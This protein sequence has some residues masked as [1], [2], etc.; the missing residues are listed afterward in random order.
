MKNFLKLWPNAGSVLLRWR[1]RRLGS[2]EMKMI[3]LAALLLGLLSGFSNTWARWQR[4][5]EAEYAVDFENVKV[6][7]HKDATFNLETEVSLEIL[8]D[9]A[10]AKFGLTRLSYNSRSSSFKVL[11]A[12][13]INGDRVL[14]VRSEH[15]ENK[16]LASSG[17]G[18]DEI[19]QVTIAFPEVNVGSKLYMRFTREVTKT[20]IP[21][22]FSWS[23]SFGLN[24]YVK[25][26]T[27]QVDSDMPLNWEVFDPEKY[28]QVEAQGKGVKARLL[29]PIYRQVTEEEN[30]KT[31]T[32][33]MPWLGITSLAKWSEFPKQTLDVYE[34]RLSSPLP[35]KYQ[36]IVQQ[37]KSKNR[38][39]DVI[40]EVIS[41][42][43][44][45]IRY[46][47]DWVP[48]E[49]AIHPRPLATVAETGFGDCKDFATGAAAMLRKLGFDA[50]A[51][52]V[53]RDR[54][55]TT[56]PLRV[57]FFN[58]N[59]T[60]V[61]AEKGGKT[62]WLDPTNTT[63]FAQGLY[64]DI[65]NREALVL[66]DSPVLKMIPPITDAMGSVK[67]NAQVDIHSPRSVE[68][69]GSISLLGHAMVPFTGLALSYS[70]ASIDYDLLYFVSVPGRVD[71]FHFDDFDLSSRIVRDLTT[72]F[73]V[74]EKWLPVPTSAGTGYLVSPPRPIETFVFRRED[75]Q[76]SLY[77]GPPRTV[78]RELVFRKVGRLDHK[79]QCEGHSEWIDF[80]R[81][82]RK[83]GSDIVLTEKITL[84][85]DRVDIDEIRKEAFQKLQDS[86]N[87]CQQ[88]AILVLRK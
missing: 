5:D 15:I 27:L 84:K 9:V 57:P 41:R 86:L 12:K 61:Y 87:L 42:L 14:P 58:F 4:P 54:N 78:E 50:H 73:T 23:S 38:D 75:R 69:H 39:V 68:L 13:T 33:A 1:R 52:F 70:K 74:T 48:V 32:R 79:V 56:V 37:A 59:H 44:E 80:R 31:D 65:A 66:L 46:V 10:R 30:V 20:S 2:E 64:E 29:R 8:K 51:A 26:S 35:E 67:I 55:D 49:G 76:S 62:Y 47:G 17:P 28:L 85:K 53:R 83:R 88:P 40:N 6:T 24:E 7:V 22:F 60:I 18:F 16:P 36:Q 71:A 82:F 21:G 19:R 45:A 77:L 81:E 43:E 25:N 34:Q 63:S 11:E 72:S 3:W